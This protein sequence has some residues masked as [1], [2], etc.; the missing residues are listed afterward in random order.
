MSL[1]ITNVGALVDSGEAEVKT[2][3]FGTQ[4]RASDY[5]EHGTPVI[6]VRNIGFGHIRPEKLEYIPEEV[7]SRLSSHLLQQGDIVFGRKGAVERH[8]YIRNAQ[9][10]WFQGSDCLR[11]RL[12]SEK[13]ALSRYLSY[14]FL[15]H[16]HQSWMMQQCS[17]GATMASLNQ[18]IIKRIPLKLPSVEK[19]SK[20]IRV[21]STYDDLIENNSRRIEI[22]E[23]MAR[24]LYEEWFVHFRFPRHQEV[25]FKESE[26]G[27]IPEGWEVTTVKPL[28]NRLKNGSVYKQKDVEESGLTI[29]ID[30]SRAEYLGFHSNKPDHEASNKNPIIIFGDHTCKMQIMV[31]PFSLG[32]NTIAFTGKTEHSLYY[33]FA[34]VRGLIKTQEYKRHWSDFMGKTIVAAPIEISLKYGELVEPM[35]RQIELL[36]RKIWNLRAQRDLLLPKLVSGEIDVSDFPM[37]DDKEIEA[38]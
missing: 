25:E 16:E 14:V 32:P 4:L 2:G 1:K 37:P 6:N 17:H 29:V 12:T 19:Q 34:L 15:T 38:A 27:M 22:L 21:L 28:I 35:F 26:L 33:I 9:D 8:V 36:R 20:I 7:V 11:L 13:T 23:Q 10:K 5:V 18:D 24:R 30:Q 31:T 3:P